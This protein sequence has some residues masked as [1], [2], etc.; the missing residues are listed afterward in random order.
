MDIEEDFHQTTDEL[1]GMWRHA[2][3]SNHVENLS[4][5]LFLILKFIWEVF[6]YHLLDVL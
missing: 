3:G 2:R 5:D 6:H 4:K 1:I